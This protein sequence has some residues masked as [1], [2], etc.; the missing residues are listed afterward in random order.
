VPPDQRRLA[1]RALREQVQALLKTYIKARKAEVKTRRRVDRAAAGSAVRGWIALAAPTA[2]KKRLILDIL[3]TG[4]MVLPADKKLGSSMAGAYLMWTPFLRTL[5]RCVPSFLTSLLTCMLAY[6]A[7][8]GSGEEDAAREGMHDWVLHILT[9]EEWRGVRRS[10]DDG[11]AAQQ[12][13]HQEYRAETQLLDQMLGLVFTS[14]SLWTLKLAATLL[15]ESSDEVVPSRNAWLAVLEAAKADEADE[16]HIVLE[17][18]PITAPTPHAMD[19]DALET[20]MHVSS[21]STAAASTSSASAAVRAEKPVG[22]RKKVGLW[23]PQPIG[24]IPPGWE[25]D[26]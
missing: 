8:P 12:Q 3:V 7:K 26:E 22:P 6:M 25:R 4:A 24:Y 17:L 2:V 5:C 23:R 14:P 11:H 19:V 9:S 1:E 20:E 21:S 15:E 13:Q 16:Q 18:D 10:T